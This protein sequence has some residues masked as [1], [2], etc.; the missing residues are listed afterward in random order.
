MKVLFL[1]RY[2]IEGASSRYRVYQYLDALQKLGVQSKVSSFMEKRM[3]Q[4]VFSPKGRFRK[5]IFAVLAVLRRLW[6]VLFA[7]RYDLVVMQRELLPFGPPLLER[8][9]KLMGIP[10]VFDY[11]DALFVHKDSK[12]NQLA[13]K[14]RRPEKTIEIF[15]LVNAVSAGNQYLAEAAKPYCKHSYCVE[16]AEDTDRIPLRDY[17]QNNQSNQNHDQS[18]QQKAL[19]VIG[20][21]GSKSTEKYLELIKPALEELFSTNENLQMKVIGGGDFRLDSTEVVHVDW[22]LDSE[23]SELLGF[24]IGLMPLPLEEWSEG[25]SGGKARTYMAAGVVPVCTGI[26]YNLELIDQERTGY[27]VKST[28]EWL[29]ALVRLVQSAG[30]RQKIGLAARQEVI[31]RFSVQGQAKKLKDIFD[32]VA[33]PNKATL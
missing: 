10:L 28:E 32:L 8:F 20:W 23:V 15:S 3:Y 26:G 9:I 16:V 7:W 21:L 30:L 33:D 27:L 2:P 1:T 11:D 12:Y 6:V 22:A 4:L 5:L 29:S 19:V 31:N 17:N 25:K 14:L 13:S 24:D 18:Y